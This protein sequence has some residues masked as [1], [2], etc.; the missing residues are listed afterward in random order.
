MKSGSAQEEERDEYVRLMGNDLGA[1]FYELKL[2][3]EWLRDKWAV[4]QELFEKGSDRVALLN[5]T[6]SNFFYFLGQ[7][8][9]EDAM[10][11]LARLT[12]PPVS[13]VHNENRQNLTV[14]TLAD[15]I[16]DQSFRTRVMSATNEFLQSC[17]FARDVRNRR[18]AH[19]DLNTHRNNQTDSLPPVGSDDV[20]EALR[21]LRGLLSCFEE[22]Y[23]C[24]PIILLP[25][26]WG[27]K[28]LVHH[29]ENVVHRDH[30]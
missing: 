23:R 4:F 3:E 17:T 21:S 24:T 8:L 28:S 19:T 12:D 27:V 1:L 18:L 2:E 29:L 22:H 30:G 6:A 14:R 26:R 15:L 5:K 11:H 13:R 16:P 7:L 9:Y 20:V 25:D 10:L